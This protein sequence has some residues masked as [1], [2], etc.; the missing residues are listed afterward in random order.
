MPNKQKLQNLSGQ[1]HIVGVA[2]S[3]KLGKVPEK[4][5][6][7]REIFDLFT[8]QN[9]SQREIAKILNEKNIPRQSNYKRKEKYEDRGQYAPLAVWIPSAIK[10]VL[11]N[12]LVI[13]EKQVSQQIKDE[14]GKRIAKPILIEGKPLILKNF[15][16]GK[17]IIS[18]TQFLKAQSL[19]EKNPLHRGKKSKGYGRFD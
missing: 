9:K 5:P 6:L 7:V 16:E 1:A 12:R 19:L 13:N 17:P 18:K 10:E 3:N 2:E 11:I 15:I 14:D 4:S 8:E